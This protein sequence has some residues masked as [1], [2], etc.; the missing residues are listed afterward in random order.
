MNLNI[1]GWTT[2]HS[3][4]FASHSAEGFVPARVAEEHR[5]RYLIFG[6]FGER[7]AEVTG[8]LRFGASSRADFPA[9][10]DWVAAQ[11]NSPDS[12]AIIH[13]ILPRTTSFMRKVV[14]KTTDVQVVA[15][16]VDTVFLVTDLGL[17]FN[18]RRLERY[19]TLSH[20][21]G[22]VPVIVLNKADLSAEIEDHIARVAS[23]AVGVPVHAVSATTGEGIQSLNPYLTTGKTVALLGSSGVGKSTIINCLLGEERLA[24]KEI[25]ERY[26]RGRHT[27]TSR[28]LILLPSGGMVIDTPGLREIQL[29]GEESSLDDTFEDITSL[30]SRCRFN[31]CTHAGEPG[32]AVQE[33]LADGSLDTGRW[34]SYQKLK[35]ELQFLERRQHVRLMLEDKAKWKRLY[36]M[37]QEQ[38]RRKRGE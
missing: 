3:E 4:Q 36:R 23:I 25:R 10:G 30:A 19:L 16:N 20:E 22:A 14:D 29:W 5:E 7:N 33:A 35:R 37:G 38:A 27:T 15:A 12:P 21:S 2:S 26:G 8:K 18:L 1:L 24:T 34:E 31:D 17:D 11:V 6:E 28:Q 13:S 32:C 9:V